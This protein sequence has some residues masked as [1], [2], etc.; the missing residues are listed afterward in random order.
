MQAFGKQNLGLPLTGLNENI[1][2]LSAA[3][4]DDFFKE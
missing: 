3:Q 4:M 2:N 1:N